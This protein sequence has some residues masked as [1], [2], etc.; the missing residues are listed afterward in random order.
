MHITFRAIGLDFEAEV[1][2]LPMI[3]G[4]YSG[5]PEDCYPDEAAEISITSLITFTG[6]DAMFLLGSDCSDEIEAAAYSA[7]ESACV[8]DEY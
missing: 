8:S 2:Y 7:A 6:K 5:P 3:P 4:R 1:D